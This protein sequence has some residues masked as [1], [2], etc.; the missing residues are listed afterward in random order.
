MLES[1]DDDV[2]AFIV[3]VSVFLSVL[4]SWSSLL[5]VK[6][7]IWAKLFHLSLISQINYFKVLFYKSHSGILT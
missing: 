4:N 6:K 3:K 5:S 7:Y 2:Y 1:N